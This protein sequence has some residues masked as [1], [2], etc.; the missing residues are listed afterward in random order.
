MAAGIEVVGA[1]APL[2]GFS[3]DMCAPGLTLS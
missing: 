1:A 3:W 2:A